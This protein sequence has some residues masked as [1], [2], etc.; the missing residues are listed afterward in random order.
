[1][2]LLLDT[3]IYVLWLAK[4]TTLAEKAYIAIANPQNLVF[5]SA[6]SILEIA[7]KQAIGKLRA[8]EPPELMLEACR[9]RELPVN[10][11]HASTFR[12]LPPLHKDPFDR[13]LLAQ[14]LVEGLTLVTRDPVMRQYAIP[15]IAA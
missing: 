8:S 9:F 15:V 12:D 2:R 11:A 13:L 4:P 7:T 5:I 3:Y 6:V 14:A 1:V 10:R